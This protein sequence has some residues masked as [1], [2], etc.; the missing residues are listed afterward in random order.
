M[1]SDLYKTKSARKLL[2]V[3]V[4]LALIMSVGSFVLFQSQRNRIIK[5]KQ[6]E[7]ATISK[8][9]V[10]QIVNWQNERLGNAQ[11]VLYNIS[12]INDVKEYSNGISRVEKMKIISSWI[13]SMKEIYHYSSVLLLDKNENI[14]FKT[15]KAELIGKAG[16]AMIKKVLEIEKPLLSD[17]HRTVIGGIHIDLVIPLFA[18]SKNKKELTGFLFFR[19]N[20][21]Q[22]LFPLIQTWPVPSYSGETNLVRKEGNTVLFLNELKSQKNSALN[23]YTPLSEMNS[24][25]VR[26]VFGLNGDFEGIDYRGKRVLAN[27]QKIPDSKW[28]IYTKIDKDEILEPI[29]RQA[30]WIFFFTIGLISLT[31]V[32]VFVIWKLH[33]SNSER[34]RLLLVKHFDY[35][36]KYANDIIIL[37]DLNGNIIEVNDKAVSIYGY[38][39]NELLKINIQYLR[40]SELPYTFEQKVDEI[41]GKKGLVYETFHITKNK[42]SFPVEISG[43]IIEVDGVEYLQ[44]IIRDITERKHI[45]EALRESEEL[46]RRLVNAI[47]DIIFRCDLDGNILFVNDS[48]VQIY[49]FEDK[50]ELLGQNIFTFIAPEDIEKAVTNSKLMF[51]QYVGPIEY[52][53]VMTDGTLAD[54][55]INGDVLLSKEGTPYGMVFIL[56]DVTERK[57]FETSLRIAKEMAEESDRLK[58]AFLANMSH[59]IRTP[60]NGIL[61]FSELLNDDSLDHTERQK[62]VN[63]ISENSRHLLGV[64]NDIIDISKIDCNQLSINRV[65]FNLNRLMDEVLMTYQ[66][67]KTIKNKD[68]LDIVMNKSLSDNNCFIISDDIR[69]RQILY[70]LIGNALKFTNKGF[71]K[72]EYLLK[73]NKL[74]FM[75]QDTG[76][77]ISHEKQSIVFERFRQEE[78]TYTRYFGGSGLGLSISKGLAELLGGR[79]WLESENGKGATFFFTIDYVPFKEDFVKNQYEF[80]T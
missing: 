49:G 61:G 42:M 31:G 35:L 39:R 15:E 74:Q 54:F 70:N 71:I 75:V 25:A 58:T 16:H 72:F 55:E 68:Q 80:L 64:I 17:L 34:E 23:F 76:K 78:E 9:K 69:L 52:K 79:L 7:L 30:Y 1:N 21:N 47:P 60:M 5:E 77:G 10:Q 20:P 3:F 8:Y 50:K 46:Y 48:N 63:V 45:E 12:F 37:S 51:K 43:R 11:S 29:L 67:E 4:I 22:F 41:V 28:F 26:A 13:K 56:R 19:I 66:N 6:Y 65:P 14:I 27:L 33:I 59:E 40:S 32:I 73:D 57:N 38:T 53:I 36:V 44:S 2:Y 18:E 62:F 24:P